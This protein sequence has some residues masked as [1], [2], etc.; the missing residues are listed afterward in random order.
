MALSA[1]WSW[2]ARTFGPAIAIVVVQQILFPSKELNDGAYAWGLVVQGI[3]LGMLGALVAL[4]MALVYRANRILN[5]AQG[6]LG[7][8]PVSL[9]IDLILL[10]RPQLLRSACLH[11][12]R[13]PR[14]SSARWSSWRSS[15][16]SSASPR[17]ILT[18][19]TIGLA[20]LLAFG[21]LAL[22]ALW[23]EG[24]LNSTHH[25]PDHVAARSPAAHLQR[26][27]PAWRWVLAPLAMVAIALF[28]RFTDVGVAARA[29][30][31][32]ADRASLLGIPVGRLHT[33]VWV[34]ATVLSF[35]AL[36]LQAG[37]RRHAAR[38]DRSA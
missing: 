18:V 13:R 28:L 33:C 5:F 29:A 34:I 1:R 19:A 3:T 10:L 24:P 27:L 23:G 21:A 9:A 2:F 31:D 22:P 17:L 35:L 36:F 7:L 12:P 26:R 30:A 11:R 16:G 32:R 6:D 14:S 8:L 15:A 38:L 4:G 20:Q 37:H 25:H